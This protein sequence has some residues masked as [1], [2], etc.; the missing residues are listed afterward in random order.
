[1][2]F[3]VKMAIEKKVWMQ[4]LFK[5]SKRKQEYAYSKEQKN[6]KRES[7]EK[8]IIKWIKNKQK[9][10]TNSINKQTIFKHKQIK[11]TK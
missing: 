1:M 9:Q 3:F 5:N 7:N 8:D 6:L 4:K 10:R 11:K 2:P